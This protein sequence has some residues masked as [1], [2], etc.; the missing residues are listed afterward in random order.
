MNTTSTAS[1]RLSIATKIHFAIKRELGEGM[2]IERMLSERAYA[3]EVLHV[4]RGLGSDTLHV[5]ANRFDAETAAESARFH[6]AQA[7]I[8]ARRALA[9]IPQRAP[10]HAA[11]AGDE[12]GAHGW[13][14]DSSAFNITGPVPLDGPVRMAALVTPGWWNSIGRTARR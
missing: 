12:A 1:R 8:S 14:A 13:S 4:C 7:S 5:L 9:Q 2:S 6:L 10:E 11:T 3:A